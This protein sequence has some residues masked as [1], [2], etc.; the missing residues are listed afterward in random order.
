MEKDKAS[1]GSRG[2]LWGGSILKT[3]SYSSPSQRPETVELA[4]C[5]YWGGLAVHS[6]EVFKAGDTGVSAVAARPEARLSLLKLCRAVSRAVCLVYD[7]KAS[8]A[9]TLRVCCSGPW[10]GR[11]HPGGQGS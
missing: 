5:G 8:L 1:Q 6:R 11:G 4:L 3:F 9:V 7:V 10:V 2:H